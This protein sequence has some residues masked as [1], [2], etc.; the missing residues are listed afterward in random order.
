MYKSVRLGKVIVL[1]CQCY[2]KNYDTESTGKENKFIE[3]KIVRLKDN[4][5][6]SWYVIIK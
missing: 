4:K 2:M 6:Y 3:R 5:D 1:H